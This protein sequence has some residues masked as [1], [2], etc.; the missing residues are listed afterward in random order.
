MEM[1]KW[2]EEFGMTG[3]EWLPHLAYIGLR[4]GKWLFFAAVYRSQNIVI[5]FVISAIYF[6]PSDLPVVNYA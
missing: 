5:L 4:L 2:R 1:N 3:L 6:L